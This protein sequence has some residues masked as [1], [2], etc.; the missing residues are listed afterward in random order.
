MKNKSIILIAL[1][2]S[3][4]IL[5]CKVNQQNISTKNDK[6]GKLTEREQQEC[7]NI[8]LEANREKI[9]GN[10][11]KA[12]SLFAECIRKN[13]K[14]HASFYE[15]ASILNAE[16]KYEDALI[17]A[18]E[19]VSLNPEN[20]WYHIL[21]AEIFNKTRQTEE[22]VKIYK[23]LIKEHPLKTDY[24]YELAMMYLYLYKYNDAIKIYNQLEN[25]IGIHEDLSLQ[26]QSIYLLNGNTSKAIEEINKLIHIFPQDSKYKIILADMYMSI[27][28]KQKAF[29]IYKDIQITDPKN[30][31]LNLSL[32]EYY[33]DIG[34]DNMFYEHIKQAFS[35]INV[36]TDS[37]IKILLSYYTETENQKDTFL[38][39]QAYELLDILIKTHPNEAITYSMYG[40]FLI[41]DKKNEE[42]AAMFLTALEIEPG[43]YLLWEQLLYIHSELKDYSILDSL[44]EA[45]LELFPE[46]AML[47]LFRGFAN[48]Q[49]KNY[50]KAVVIFKEGLV[51]AVYDEK[52]ST[53]FYMYMGDAYNHLKKY[54]ESDN[55][56]DN[57]LKID[58]NNVGILNNYSYYLSLRKEKLE[59]A[60]QMSKKSND[61]R[62]N[63]PSYQDTYAWILFQLEEYEEAVLWI[64]KAINNGGNKNFVII[65]HYGDILYKLN[66]KDEALEQWKKAKETAKGSVEL[67]RKIETKTLND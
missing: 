6:K 17:L 10:Y 34:D 39:R 29:D 28:E 42:A 40:D 48:Y 44:S 1:V 57:A 21:L 25:I 63:I 60:K 3:F 18:K 14:D 65:E 52:L 4:S 53:E 7:L 11:S 46:R 15:L 62:P 43:K 66:K 16:K 9:L 54:E 2:L 56:F 20:E 5:A 47:Y 41:R 24:Y 13:D 19:A 51:Y 32:A 22:A 8:F 33:R 59:K 49:L 31:E 30:E 23:N 55:A 27:G 36:N 50:E 45:A 35:N 58:P 61:I 37:K 38:L 26:K 12:A 64:E 67:D